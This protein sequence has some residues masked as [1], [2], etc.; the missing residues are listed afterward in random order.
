MSK[1]FLSGV[2]LTIAAVFT[3]SSATLGLAA[4]RD[5]G[6][7]LRN[8][9]D[10]KIQNV[11]GTN[12]RACNKGTSIPN[13]A[14]II[15]SRNLDQFA[16]QW[17]QEELVEKNLVE[18]PE[19]GKKGY[20]VCFSS[21]QVR[22]PSALL[23]FLPGFLRYERSVAVTT[24]MHTRGD[25]QPVCLPEENATLISGQPITF[26]WCGP[27]AILEIKEGDSG[28][29]LKSIPLKPE[30]RFITLQPDEL[31][32]AAGKTYIW[33]V[34]GLFKEATSL[35]M[36]GQQENQEISALL[37]RIDEMN[38]VSTG[39]KVAR[40][41]VLLK[42]LQEEYPGVYSFAWLIH[43]I[44]TS[45]DEAINKFDPKLAQYLIRSIEVKECY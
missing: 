22:N 10:C 31:S 37:K 8:E 17:R 14:V 26:F 40:K 23:A 24:S 29:L 13:G 33:R 4:D 9:G 42:V 34:K 21:K 11:N 45:Q 35:K 36:L 20:K 25:Q 16:I 1:L 32:L 39:E 28:I 12:A 38:D 2:M 18:V 15:T 30:N 3:V 19:K 7:F 44:L 41:V 6:L 5:I 43:G 27:G